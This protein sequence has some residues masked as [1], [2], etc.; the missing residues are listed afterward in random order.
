MDTSCRCGTSRKYHSTAGAHKP[1]ETAGPRTAA[2]HVSPPR[3]PRSSAT[4]GA[5]RDAKSKTRPRHQGSRAASLHAIAAGLG[6]SSPRTWAAFHL[7]TLAS[8]PATSAGL[9]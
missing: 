4:K 5:S 1:G 9:V 6:A 2:C 3:S 7:A 8:W